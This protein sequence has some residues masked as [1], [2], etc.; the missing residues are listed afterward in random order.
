[1]DKYGSNYR[2]YILILAALTFTFVVAMPWMCMPVLF[3]EIAGDLNLSLVQIGAVWSMVPLGGLFFILIG[4]MLGDRFSVQ[5][6]LF[7]T[8]L[9]GGLVGAARGL[10]TNFITLAV[11]MFLF[12]IPSALIP[13]VGHKTASICFPGRGFAQGILTVGMALGFMMGAMI[14]ATVLSPLLGSWRIVMFL[15]GGMTI[16][17]SVLWLLTFSRPIQVESSVDNAATVPL[18][19]ALSRVVRYKSVW[20]LGFIM[21]CHIGCIQGLLGFL[22]LY[23]R[24]IG[25]TATGADGTSTAFHGASMIASIPIAL[26]SDR[27][28][29]RKGPILVAF[30]I[31]TISVGLL[32]LISGGAV[33]AIVIIAGIFRDGFVAVFM[34]TTIE[35]KGVG[36]AYAGTALGLTLTVARLGDIISPLIGNGLA[37]IN[38]RLAF[39]FWAALAAVGLVCSYFLK[40]TG[41]RSKNRLEA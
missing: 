12:G 37:T 38:P 32:S 23:L 35:T 1:L 20:L 29:S 14:S 19:Q 2:W 22:P 9:I 11:T 27:L 5:R 3:Q 28:G 25:W 15:Y 21:L 33:W 8:C 4:G 17:I 30:L 7:V 16:V 31:H 10:S 26:L 18:R 41:W 36:A 6:F 40:E 39:V 34:S 24:G 13:P